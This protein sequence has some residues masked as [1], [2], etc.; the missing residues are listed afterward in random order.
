MDQMGRMGMRVPQDLMR[1][2][3]NMGQAESRL[4]RKASSNPPGTSKAKPLAICAKAR[5]KWPSR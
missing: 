3:S 1:A 4:G 5:A 2:G